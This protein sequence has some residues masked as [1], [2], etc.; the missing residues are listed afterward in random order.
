MKKLTLKADYNSFLAFFD[1]QN[2]K[3]V[4]YNTGGRYSHKLKKTE[5][6]IFG[7]SDKCVGVYDHLS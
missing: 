5:D 6:N 1:A 7:S 2:S 3:E 4:S